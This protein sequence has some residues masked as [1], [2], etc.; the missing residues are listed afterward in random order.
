MNT[1]VFSV[2][3]SRASPLS[4]RVPKNPPPP[5]PPFLTHLP[6]LITHQR[7]RPRMWRLSPRRREGVSRATPHGCRQRRL[8]RRRARGLRSWLEFVSIHI[9]GNR[10]CVCMYLYSLVDACVCVMHAC[11]SVCDG[12][13]SYICVNDIFVGGRA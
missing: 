9:F 10:T 6:L 7:P 5:L 11:V 2:W 4:P 12:G 13:I 1:P 3:I 8:P